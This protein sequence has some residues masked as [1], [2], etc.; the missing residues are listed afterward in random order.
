MLALHARVC[1]HG[2]QRVSTDYLLRWAAI[3][4]VGLAVSFGLQHLGVAVPVAPVRHMVLSA[5]LLLASV[6]V[7]GVVG[8]LTPR[9]AMLAAVASD[10][11][12]SI[13]QFVVMIAVFLPLSYMAAVPSLPLLDGQLARLDALL[14]GFDWDTAAQWVANQPTLEWVLKT[15]YSSGALQIGAMLLLGSLAQ[16]GERNS[17]FIWQFFTAALL[18]SVIFVFTPALGKEGHLTYMATLVAL[19]SGQWTVFDYADAQGIVTFPSFHASCGILF[20]Y[21]ARRHPWALAAVIPLNLLMIAATP[22]IGGHYLVDLLGG[23]GV[24][25]GAIVVARVLRKYL[26]PSIAEAIMR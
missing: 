14:F 16:P 11:L 12:L 5:A 21:A 18:T 17:E 25:A 4:I 19:R 24:A 7:Y 10:F 20:V 1:P 22:P 9:T 6:P 13:L 26:L 2:F 3:G 15:A 23:A 8:R